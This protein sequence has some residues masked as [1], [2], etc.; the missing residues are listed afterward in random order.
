[1]FGLFNLL[2]CVQVSL[3]SWARSRSLWRR[4]WRRRASTWS[5]R[6][7]SVVT[8][9]T[10]SRVPTTCLVKEKHA[11]TYFG[12]QKPHARKKTSKL[13][14]G[15]LWLR[16]RMSENSRKIFMRYRSFLVLGSWEAQINTCFCERLHPTCYIIINI[17]RFSTCTNHQCHDGVRSHYFSQES[18]L[19]CVDAALCVY[20]SRRCISVGRWAIF[21]LSGAIY[22]FEYAFPF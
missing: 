8:S 20:Q 6:S 15:N 21:A 17:T 2:L 1:M 3:R 9:P 7:S 10:S 12:L 18:S 11:H 22:M 14:V 5:W 19:P 16:P 13:N 4:R